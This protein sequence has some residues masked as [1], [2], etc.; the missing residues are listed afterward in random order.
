MNIC[1]KMKCQTC[2]RAK[3]TTYL[4]KKNLCVD[5]F[6]KNKNRVYNGLRIKKCLVCGKD[7]GYRNKKYCS[8]ECF[9]RSYK[10]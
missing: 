3:A 1:L 7:Q 8:R 5:C 6:L 4:D 9:L 10:K 2:K